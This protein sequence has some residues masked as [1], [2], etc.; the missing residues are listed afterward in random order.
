MAHNRST[1]KMG[2]PDRLRKFGRPWGLMGAEA[3]NFHCTECPELCAILPT[4]L[5]K[6]CMMTFG[7]LEDVHGMSIH[8]RAL[9]VPF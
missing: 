9:R 7:T 4:F 3:S 6:Y 5:Q 1:R 8:G 2:L